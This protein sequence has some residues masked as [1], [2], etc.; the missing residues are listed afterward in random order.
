MVHRTEVCGKNEFL[1]TKERLSY[2][3]DM[4]GNRRDIERMQCMVSCCGPCCPSRDMQQ[5]YAAVVCIPRGRCGRLPI[6]DTNTG[7][8]LQAQSST[9]HM[10]TLAHGKSFKTACQTCLSCMWRKAETEVLGRSTTCRILRR[11]QISKKG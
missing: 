3:K 2:I 8:T 9:G 4:I 5:E 6:N 10:F 7:P 1:R 11:P